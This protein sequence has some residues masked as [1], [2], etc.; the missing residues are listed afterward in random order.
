MGVGAGDKLARGGTKAAFPASEPGVS[1]EKFNDAVKDFD[2]VAYAERVEAEEKAS[3]DRKNQR[4]ITEEAEAE[5][6]ERERQQRRSDSNIEE[7]GIPG[8]KSAKDLAN[9]AS[10]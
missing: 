2:P 3:R 8:L 1:E 4:L 5:Q 7:A 10:K 6:R 9:T